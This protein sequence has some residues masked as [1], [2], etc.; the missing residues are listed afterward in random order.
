MNNPL[1]ILLFI[2]SISINLQ[3]Q[4]L[5]RTERKI[6]EKVKNFDNASLLFLEKVV[7]INS[8][9]LNQ[10]GVKEVGD[11]FDTAFQEI[12]FQTEWINMPAE[13]NRAGH[14]FASIN[15]DKGK[16]LLLIGHLDT[17][18]EENSPFQT[19]ERINDSI[20]YGPGANDMKGG[21]VVVLYALKALADLNLLKRASITVAFTGDEESTGKPLSISRRALIEAG[22]KADIALGFE[23]A[24]GFDNATIARRGASGWS[25]EVKGIRAHSSGVFNERIGAGAIFEMSRIL[26]E[27]YT[28]VRGEEYLTFNPGTLLGGTFIDYDKQTSSGEVFGKTNVVAQTAIVNGGLRFI[29]EEQKENARAKMRTIVSQNLPQT[30]ASI[31]FID[32]YPAMGPTEGNQAV[33]EILSEVSQDLGF[34]PVT[35]Y[36]P[37]KRGAADISF[38]ADYVD[39]LD[40]LG[41][42]GNYAH[43]PQETV[44]LK[45]MNALIQRAAILI[46]RLTR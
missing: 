8:G 7:N 11:L 3:A 5:N 43:T 44:N 18:F 23:N 13:M 31:N 32:S 2:T 30:S 29:S 26:N 20:A 17:V 10:N 24:T 19:F 40:G 35:G 27:F 36:D 38:V 28:E 22:K 1:L 12:G 9:T 6:V 45:T 4:K 46:Y 41:T 16:K 21:D 39:G 37:S 25:V 34:G 33:L 14:L 15:G 42:M